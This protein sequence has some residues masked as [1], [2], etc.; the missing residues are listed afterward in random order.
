MAIEEEE[1]LVKEMFQTAS[2]K[3]LCDMTMK[4]KQSKNLYNCLDDI[5]KIKTAD[6]L[7]VDVYERP[8]YEEYFPEMFLLP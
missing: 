6:K 4:T 2:F 1:K 7:N 8:I 5:F 3:E